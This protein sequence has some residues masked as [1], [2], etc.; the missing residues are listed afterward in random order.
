MERMSILDIKGETSALMEEEV[1][2]IHDLSVNLHSLSRIQTSVCWQQVR[3]K[4]LQEEDANT[5]FLILLCLQGAVIMS[6]SC[7]RL[8]VFKLKGFK[9]SK[10]QSIII[11]HPIF[12][13]LK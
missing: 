2:E 7:Y 8:T 5:F 3:L 10:A 4:W 13:M 11:F 1:D 9:T 6:F 12:E